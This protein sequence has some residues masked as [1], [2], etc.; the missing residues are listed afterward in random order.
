[1]L[2]P[3]LFFSLRHGVY[4][5]SYNDKGPSKI[6]GLSIGQISGPSS[7]PGPNAF[8]EDHLLGGTIQSNI[9]QA[10]TATIKSGRINN[11][12]VRNL[13][14][15]VLKV[16]VGFND[17]KSLHFNLAFEEMKVEGLLDSNNHLAITF[18]A[19]SSSTLIG[20]KDVNKDANSGD[21]FNLVNSHDN[22]GKVR[23]LKGG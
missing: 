7:V 21:T 5:C 11:L 18:H 23:D 4:R 9:G 14:D 22:G 1:M 13:G 10:D 3:N 20:V 19:T 15:S 2:L 16:P 8:L 12:K 17:K 6:D